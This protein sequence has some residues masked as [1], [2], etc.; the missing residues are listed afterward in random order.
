MG[1][2]S[3]ILRSAP[4]DKWANMS[5]DVKKSPLK[6]QFD[7]SL[8]FTFDWSLL[9]RC[10]KTTKFLGRT[11]LHS[12]L[13]IVKVLYTFTYAYACVYACVSVH[14]CELALECVCMID[15]V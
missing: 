11:I 14:V 3:N 7:E 5:K 13:K 6:E 10:L 8:S 2:I 1:A 9:R 12:I 15:G 4:K